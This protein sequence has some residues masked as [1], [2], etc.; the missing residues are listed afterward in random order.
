[1]LEEAGTALALGMPQGKVAGLLGLSESVFSRLLKRNG[2]EAAQMLL[3]CK[4]QGVK[5]N[6]SLVQKHAERNWQAAA[7]LLERCNGLDYAQRTQANGTGSS[8]AGSVLIQL[9]QSTSKTKETTKQATVN[10]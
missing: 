10:V 5:R 1:M 9:I 3:E 2:N 8:S 7:W 6:L 4:S